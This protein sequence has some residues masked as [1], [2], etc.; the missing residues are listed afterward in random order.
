MRKNEL[1]I[2][3]EEIAA[4]FLI[5]K[6]YKILD[7]N[8][9]HKTKEIDIIA[10]Q[11]QMLVIVEVKSRYHNFYEDP[12]E[13]VTEQKQRFLIHATDAYLRKKN[14]DLEARFDVISVVFAPGSHEIDHIEGAFYPTL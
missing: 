3:G 13:A 5:K 2:K 4:A 11:K 9:R 10:Q 12:R 8:W 14:I 1:G 7:K 6:G